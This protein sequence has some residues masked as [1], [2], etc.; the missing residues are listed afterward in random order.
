MDGP[1]F[2][3]I[4]F[5]RELRVRLVERPTLSQREAAAEAGVSNATFS[6]AA[7]GDATLSHENWLRLRRWLDT[8]WEACAHAA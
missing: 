2:D 3:S 6:R 4:G 1:L 8:K 5:A 7:R